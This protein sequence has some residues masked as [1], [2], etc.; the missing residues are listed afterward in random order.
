MDTVSPKS[1][2]SRTGFPAASTVFPAKSSPFPV[3]ASVR[4]EAAV[5]RSPIV[6]AWFNIVPFA[7][8][9]VV[10]SRPL[11]TLTIWLPPLLSPSVVR[12]TRLSVPV[13]PAFQRERPLPLRT[14]VL[15]L[16]SFNVD[17]VRFRSLLRLTW[18]ALL[19]PS[20]AVEMFPS[21]RTAMVL[22]RS[23]FTAAPPSAVR[24]NPPVV[25]S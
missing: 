3:T 25:W 10:P 15:P 22:P 1:A 8:C 5:F 17:D 19:S 20:T 16:A 2:W 4:F 7:S 9:K 14:A 6:A 12:E 18:M 24:P 13:V 21:P 23:C 11:F